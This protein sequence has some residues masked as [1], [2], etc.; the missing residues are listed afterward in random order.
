MAV[1]QKSLETPCYIKYYFMLCR[2]L[3]D[4]GACDRNLPGT[5]IRRLVLGHGRRKEGGIGALAPPL[6]SKIHQKSC[7]LS[8]E[9][10]KQISTLLTSPQEKFWKNLL[11]LPLQKILPKPASLAP[12]ECYFHGYPTGFAHHVEVP[13]LLLKDNIRHA[14][15]MIHS[16]LLIS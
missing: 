5:S 9:W 15:G 3:P 2:L 10:K 14:H 12:W 11:V 6:F 16:V 8:F 1:G 7:F 13:Y 4:E